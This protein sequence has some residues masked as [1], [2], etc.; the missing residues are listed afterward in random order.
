MA[1]DEESF[2]V[3]LGPDKFKVMARDM[4]EA[5]A[6]AMEFRQEELNQRAQTQMEN[7][8]A[9][10]KPFMAGSDIAQSVAEGFGVPQAMDMMLGTNITG[11]SK[12]AANRAG[13]AGTAANVLSAAKLPTAVPRVASYL[14]GG[15]A[16]RG[17]VKAATS[18]A[19]G[20]TY[21]GGQAYLRD[22]PVSENVALGGAGGVVGSVL[23]PAI[24]KG[25][26]LIRGIDDSIPQGIRSKMT[27]LP[28]NQTNPSLADRITVAENVSRR[29][30][31]RSSDPLTYQR[32]IKSAVGDI[33]NTVPSVKKGGPS[34]EIRA[35]MAGVAEDA[36]A[37]S[38]SRVM[39]NI[40]SR[41][42]LGVGL[43]GG[44]GFNPIAGLAL[45]GGQSMLGR[46]L[47]AVSSGGTE[48][49]MRDLRR[50]VAGVPKYQ[51]ILSPTA[52]NRLTKMQRQGLLEYYDE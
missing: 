10:A 39:G 15:P 30:S 29:E 2:T 34:P 4:N 45:A 37:T 24:N 44:Y 28:A 8:P 46:G 20:A 27:A 49:A 42:A 14:G 19:E 26:K 21:G 18:G 12:A 31:R 36:P 6:R 35:L 51:G 41:S 13:W 17:I 32:E 33:A 50:A 48:E 7:A 47:K 52:S 38:A 25:Y 1:D 40:A 43:A 9:W 5:R 11:E 22:Q 16:A 3:Q 23:G